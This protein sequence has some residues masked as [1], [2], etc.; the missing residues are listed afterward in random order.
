M[1][2]TKP[3]DIP[4]RV[5]WDAYKRVRANRGAA[6]VDEQSMVDFE[7]DLSGNL[8]KLWNRLSSG[9]YHPPPVRQVGIPKKSGGMRYLGVPTV[10]DRIAQTVVKRLLESQWDTHFH[11]DS[12]GYRPG[13]FAKDAV[14]VTRKRCWR[15]DWVVEFD[16]Q[17]AFDNIDYE[18]MM[19]AVRKHAPEAWMV[20]YIE[21]W[22][23][24]PVMTPDG[25]CEPRDRGTP[26]GGV[27]SPLLMNLFMHY[28]FDCWMRRTYP[29]NPF[30]RYADDAVIHCRS[31][32]QAESILS[33]LATRLADCKLH[34]HL[35]KSKIVYCKD[36]RR[37]GRYPTCQFT[38]LGFTF[39]PRC[40]QGPD[41]KL[42]TSFLP[43]VSDDAVKHMRA[44]VRS[45]RIHR[46]TNW[47]LEALAQ[48]VNRVLQG[49]WNYYGSFYPSA[50]RVIFD[51][52]NRRLMLWG[53]R[54]Y[55]RLRGRL[56]A[57]YAWLR[58]VATARPGLFVCWRWAGIP[59]AR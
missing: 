19:K 22:L 59:T 55:R 36:S 5:V 25:V 21:R 46:R 1:S 9:S 57:S 16:I 26:Q 52:F 30:A 40:A 38:F 44:V 34:L 24:A 56:L 53:R 14:A 51:Y 33:A 58:R 6:G 48:L 3:F 20:L 18:L 54:K 8:Y 35:E 47:S 45:W 15:Y 32:A 2:T 27:I 43:A 17:G 39:R 23:K 42:F 10:A 41:G 31:N 29:G 49:W 4:K 7:R 50:M 13:R 37:R 12:Y 11:P 28:A